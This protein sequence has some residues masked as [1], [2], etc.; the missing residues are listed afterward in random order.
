MT[1]DAASYETLF[2]RHASNPILTAADWPYP[3]HTVFNAGAT[4]LHGRHDAAALPRRG[5]P[6]ALASLRGALGERRRRLG[7]STRSRRS[8][9]IRSDYPGGAVGHRGPAHHVRRGAREV[10][11]R[12]YRVQQGRPR[13]G[14]RAHRGL[15]HAS[16]AAAWSCSPTTRTPRCCRAASTAASRCIHRPIDRLRART[17]GS[18]SRPTCATGAATS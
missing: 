8:G 17:S 5:P 12:V 3:A 4:R 10:R 18:R 7:R 15:P 9:P 1:H 2:H 16:S 6:R 14:A 11:D 13:R